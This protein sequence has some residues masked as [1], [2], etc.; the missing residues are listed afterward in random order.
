MIIYARVNH[1]ILICLRPRFTLKIQ[2]LD[3]VVIAPSEHTLAKKSKLTEQFHLT[4]WKDYLIMYNIQ[5]VMKNLYL[6]SD[7][8]DAK[9]KTKANRK[10]YRY[11]GIRLPMPK[12]RYSI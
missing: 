8:K 6:R 12:R 4:R 9:E 11:L 7:S 2:P 5:T 3:E 1:K 10:K